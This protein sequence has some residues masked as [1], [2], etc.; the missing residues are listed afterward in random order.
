MNANQINSSHPNRTFILSLVYTFFSGIWLPAFSQTHF[1]DVTTT[2]GI[3]TNHNQVANYYVTGQA[4]GDYDNDGW[5][6]L[7]LTNSIGA[8]TLYRN[9]GDGTFS[10]PDLNSTLS[11]A[12]RN[13]GGAVFADYNNDG[14]MDLYILNLGANLLFRNDGGTGFTD[15]TD[16]AGLGDERKGEM[17]AWADFDNDGDLDVYV[18]NWF[19]PDCVSPISIK[20][21]RDRFYRNNGDG[22]FKDIS[23]IL[24]ESNL[25]GAGFAA[26]FLDFDNDGDLDIYLVNDQFSNPIGNK[27]WRN[28]GPGC[29]EWC[30]KEISEDVGAA[31]KINGMGLAVGDFDNDLDLDMVATNI[32]FPIFLQNSAEQGQP[33]YT[34][35]VLSALS[36]LDDD[37]ITWGTFFFDFNNDQWLDLYLSNGD[38]DNDAPLPNYLLQN[39]GDGTFANMSNASGLNLSLRT[40]GAA[41][42]DYDRDGLV[43]LIAGNRN[44]GYRLY[45]NNGLETENHRWLS[46]EFK[47]GGPVHRNAAGSRAYLYLDNQQTIMQEVKCGSSHGAGNQ[48]ALHFGIGE[49]QID[50]LH[51]RWPNEEM[52]SFQNIPSGNF[53]EII[54]PD[55]L[56]IAKPFS[57]GWQLVGLPFAA[58]S[59]FPLPE[60]TNDSLMIFSG[61]YQAAD[62]L[63]PNQGYWYFSHRPQVISF[64]GAAMTDRDI[65]LNKGWNLISGLT[66]NISTDQ[67]IDAD[68]VLTPGPIYKYDSGY[69]ETFSLESGNGYWVH[70]D[71]SGVI[72]LDAHANAQSN[73][74]QSPESFSNSPRLIIR[75]AND[76]SQAL[77]FNIP[78]EEIDDAHRLLPPLP[79]GQLFDARFSGGYRAIPNAVATIELQTAG[80]PVTVELQPAAASD[81]TEW[82]LVELTGVET[83][84]IHFLRDG[85]SISITSNTKRLQLLPADKVFDTFALYQN[86]PNPF[87]P[88]TVISYS[89]PSQ[90]T[91]K[92]SIYN[93][94]GQSVKTMVSEEQSAGFYEIVWDGRDASGIQVSSGLYFY[95]IETETFSDVK[96]MLLLQ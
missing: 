59:D 23:H 77:Y 3:S 81:E 28:D 62:S 36:G 46:V 33:G 65:R 22:T 71:K 94:L 52:A 12:D 89:L 31:Q 75:D 18:V 74:T 68:Q 48:L 42:A 50:S 83:G 37:D 43:D 29:G 93:L 41:Y 85:S 60:N 6:D 8:N 35:I 21:N 5:L 30:F 32:G 95:R 72:N 63:H 61:E 17:A 11:L 9:E 66:N 96:K 38:L 87:N 49:S 82:Q 55:M 92:L 13:S 78:M 91:V 44:D 45:R 70:A 57:Q 73:V 10:Q 15:V 53:L 2:A 24:S 34:N 80:Y 64:S 79:P 19:C 86:Y 84:K 90:S 54:Y 39:N 4:W 27:L 25:E 76:N 26:G 7:Y 47:G 16:I 20:G 51:I 40:T 67:I 56:Q 1:S 14:W 69:S 58:A 88:S